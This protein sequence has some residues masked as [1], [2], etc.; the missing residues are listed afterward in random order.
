MSGRDEGA[1]MRSS[2]ARVLAAAALALVL[3]SA[4]SAA[5]TYAP[6]ADGL[7]WRF[8]CTPKDGAPFDLA[9]TFHQR[10]RSGALRTFVLTI[11]RNGEAPVEQS[12]HGVDDAGN[13]YLLGTYQNGA[14]R[15]FAAPAL[16]VPASPAPGFTAQFARADEQ[17][18]RRYVREVDVRGPDGTRL[19][20]ALF[21]DTSPSGESTS[22]YAPGVGLV[23][24]NSS[25]RSGNDVLCERA[26]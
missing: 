25:P 26:P 15:P 20:A 4:A 8:H 23:M 9:E 24:S 19:H 22:A 6:Y 11:A 2:S 12:V 3:G 14:F 16:I 10:A 18:T 1:R 21:S 17:V 13:G 7:T 5:Q